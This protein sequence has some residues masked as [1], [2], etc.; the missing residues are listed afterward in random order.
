MGTTPNTNIIVREQ[1]GQPFYEAKFR[2]YGR[3]VKRR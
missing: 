2:H 3:Q 1:G